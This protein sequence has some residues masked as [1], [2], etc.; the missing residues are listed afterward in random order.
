M[1]ARPFFDY[2]SV[3]YSPHFMY[4]IDAIK[5]VQCYFTKRLHGLKDMSYTNRL[6]ICNIES[7]EIRCLHNYL[8][9][10]Y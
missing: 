2:A 8:I 9:Q 7:L 5:S 4:L 1:Y 6:N 3:I 10:N